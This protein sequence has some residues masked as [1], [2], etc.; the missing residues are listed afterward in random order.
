MGRKPKYSAVSSNKI[1]FR[2][3]DIQ[4]ELLNDTQTI[5]K[6]KG[7]PNSQHDVFVAGLQMYYDYLLKQHKLN[8]NG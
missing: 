6:A 8:S 1:N 4:S 2:I 3:T 5:C 7:L